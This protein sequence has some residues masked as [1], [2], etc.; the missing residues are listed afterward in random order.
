MYQFFQIENLPA[1]LAACFLDE[2]KSLKLI[3]LRIL[4]PTLWKGLLLPF[5][6]PFS[7]VFSC[8][9]VFALVVIGGLE[10]STVPAE[11]LKSSR[12][13]SLSF[14]NL[15]SA[16]SKSKSE[17]PRLFPPIAPLDRLLSSVFSVPFVGTARTVIELRADAVPAPFEPVCPFVCTNVVFVGLCSRASRFAMLFRASRDSLLSR[18]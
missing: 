2:F 8:L 10:L 9:T 15:I 13:L 16:L 3:F 12:K 5:P 1:L 6:F 7:P 17:R 14:A 4:P 11:K 18:W